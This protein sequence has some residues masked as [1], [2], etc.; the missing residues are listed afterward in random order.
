MVDVGFVRLYGFRM[1]TNSQGDFVTNFLAGSR[2]YAGPHE[3][4]DRTE[5]RHGATPEAPWISNP[6]T[7]DFR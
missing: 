2:L 5:F 4:P 6:V 7:Q 3:E 1:S